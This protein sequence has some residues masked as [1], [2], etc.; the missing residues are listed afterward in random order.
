MVFF[1]ELSSV[2]SHSANNPFLHRL[3]SQDVFFDEA[4]NHSRPHVCVKDMGAASLLDVHE[5]FLGAHADAADA[6]DVGIN[7][8]AGDF[9]L[10][11]FE[12]FASAGGDATGAH[13]DGDSCAGVAASFLGALSIFAEAAKFLE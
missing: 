1:L 6:G 2:N 3:A 5:R 11:G 10:D 12:G 13:T 9:G 8:A 4:A 7:L